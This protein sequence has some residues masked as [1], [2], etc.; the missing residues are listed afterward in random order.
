MSYFCF[1]AHTE[2]IT[3]K[4]N[5]QSGFKVQHY[6]CFTRFRQNNCRHHTVLFE[7]HLKH[8]YPSLFKQPAKSWSS[9]EY[10]YESQVCKTE[11]M[12]SLQGSTFPGHPIFKLKVT[13]LSH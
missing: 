10:E 11:L 12:S 1:N 3:D 2:S 5:I 4:M 7:N 8:K 13:L 9:R 6:L